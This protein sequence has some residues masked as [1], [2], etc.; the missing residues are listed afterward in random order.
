MQLLIQRSQRVTAF[1][2][3]PIF[4]LWVKFEVT[5]E[6]AGLINQYQVENMILTEGGLA[7][8]LKIFLMNMA[9][10][11]LRLAFYLAVVIALIYWTVTSSFATALLVLIF[12][13]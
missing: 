11:Q 7:G 10:G 6:E 9:G 8:Q 12:G 13:T 5:P 1:L 4:K 2:R 3:R